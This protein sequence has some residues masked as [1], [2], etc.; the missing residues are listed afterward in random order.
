[1]SERFIRP[2]SQ[3]VQMRQPVAALAVADIAGLKLVREAPERRQVAGRRRPV[4]CGETRPERSRTRLNGSVESGDC[5][6][7]VGRIEVC[8]S[9][10]EQCF[11]IR[12]TAEF[13]QSAEQCRVGL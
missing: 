11:L 9:L 1:M 2:A 12:L 4:G 3:R 10:V 7:G 5:G 8:Q 13:P 6:A